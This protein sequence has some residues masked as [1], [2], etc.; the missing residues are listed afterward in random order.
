MGWAAD[1]PEIIRWA[2]THLDLIAGLRNGN[3]KVIKRGPFRT[4]YNQAIGLRALIKMAVGKK[5]VVNINRHLTPEHFK[6]AWTG[7]RAVNL[8]VEPLLDDET[9]EQ[10]AARLVAAGRTLADVGDLACFMYDYPGEMRRWEWVFAISVSS[11]WADDGM[12]KTFVPFASVRGA[13]REFKL[14]F[15]NNPLNRQSHGILVCE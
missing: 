8:R 11:R 6:L 15:F 10:A 3:L 4:I 13:H 5:N 12:G 2:V 9:G 14:F 1:H 7:I